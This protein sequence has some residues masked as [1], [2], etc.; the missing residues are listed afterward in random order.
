MPR[1]PS[2]IDTTKRFV[3]HHSGRDCFSPFTGQDWPAWCAFVHLV[4]CWTRGGGTAAIDAM[5]ATLRCAQPLVGVIQP[6]VQAIPAI[7]DWPHVRTLMPLIAGN[8]RLRDTHGI[9][10]TICAFERT[11]IYDR[12]HKVV[13]HRVFHHGVGR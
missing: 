5:S 12:D 3:R 4:E 1:K 6:F 11:E 2:L 10:V 13:D 7:G 9:A 8:L